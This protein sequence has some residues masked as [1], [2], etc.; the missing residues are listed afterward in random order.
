MRVVYTHPRSVVLITSRLG[1]KDNVM[2]MDWHIPLSL[3]PKL[4]AISLETKNFSYSI[5]RKSGV[6]A[7][8][9]MPASF[10]NAIVACGNISGS[11]NDKFEL[12]NLKKEEA[13]TINAPILTDA[14]GHI[15]CEVVNVYPAGD[16]TLFVAK[17]LYEKL[18]DTPDKLQ[19][20]HISRL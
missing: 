12:T 1:E 7:V 9:F 11:K 5:I 4:Y 16:H 20:Y 17:V 6:F 8:N 19:L 3:F 18:D 10:E 2:P 15:E 13:K 14:F